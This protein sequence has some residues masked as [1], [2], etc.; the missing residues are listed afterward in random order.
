MASVWDYAYAAARVILGLLFALHGAQNAVWA[1]WR[2]Y[3]RY[4]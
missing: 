3:A 4:L 1:R 2:T